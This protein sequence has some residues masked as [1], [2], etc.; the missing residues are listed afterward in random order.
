[1]LV[2]QHH[3]NIHGF[4]VKPAISSQRAPLYRQATH[5]F[6]GS[7]AL[8]THHAAM[9]T[10]NITVA[11][12]FY[13]LLGFQVETKFWAGPARAAW[14]GT[15]RRAMNFMERQELLG[16]N[17]LALDATHA[18]Q[19]KGYSQLADWIQDLNATSLA[20]FGKSLRV[21]LEPRQQIIGDSV[22]ELAFLYDADGAL[23][24]FVHNNQ[25]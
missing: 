13:S 22:Y 9:K 18:M 5:L 14:M 24:E 12:Q 23:V 11:I 17:H 20:S 1:V 4:L 6:D 25:M 15:K 7:A 16:W 19:E 8:A 10:R 2:S 21:T 3:F